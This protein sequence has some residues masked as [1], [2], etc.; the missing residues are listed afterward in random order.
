MNRLFANLRRAGLQWLLALLPLHAGFAQAAMVVAPASAA[1]MAH[2]G[3]APVQPAVAPEGAGEMP[4]AD[5]MPCH[6]EAAASQPASGQPHSPQH[7]PHKGACCDTG[8]CHCV[9][10]CGL[11]CAIVRVVA[12][13]GLVQPPFSFLSAPAAA[14][15]PDPRPPI[16]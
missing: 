7:D 13:R 9:A 1:G 12:E 3:M 4:M 10:A 14:H 2:A 16:H 5:G 8:S 11:A 15:P 6:H